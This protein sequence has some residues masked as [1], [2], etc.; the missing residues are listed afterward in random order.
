MPSSSPLRGRRDLGAPIF[1]AT[2]TRRRPSQVPEAGP[3]TTIMAKETD[4]ASHNNLE[5]VIQNPYTNQQP[6]TGDAVTTHTLQPP[7]I[8]NPHA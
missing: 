2:S 8:P 5:D 1:S 4:S 7:S 6:S 3:P